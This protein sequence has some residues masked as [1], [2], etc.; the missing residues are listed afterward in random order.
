MSE[1][2]IIVVYIAI[3]TVSCPPWKAWRYQDDFGKM[4]LNWIEADDLL[5]SQ[6]SFVEF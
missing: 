4:Y 5:Q 6:S 1:F 2:V 3:S